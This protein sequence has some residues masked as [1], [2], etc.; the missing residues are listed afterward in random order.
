MDCVM[1]EEWK[2]PTL[3]NGNKNDHTAD[4]KNIPKIKEKENY[5]AS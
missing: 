2:D 1:C 3:F 5:V 4:F